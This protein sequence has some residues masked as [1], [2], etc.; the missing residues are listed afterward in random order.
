MDNR[1]GKRDFKADNNY[2]NTPLMYFIKLMF[3]VFVVLVFSYFIFSQIFLPA[4]SPSSGDY[5]YAEYKGEW[6]QV[7][8]DGSV[9]ES[10]TFPGK[11]AAQRGEKII[12]ET[13]LPAE[14][15]S[16]KY[17]CFRSSKQDMRIWIDGE[18][19]ADYNTNDTRVFGTTSA[20]A[21]VFVELFSS[22][23]GKTLTME[24]VTDSSYTGIFYSAYY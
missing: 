12:L 2:K 15:V 6:T 14:I 24:T 18:L 9:G 5:E 22:D 11:V 17:L 21:Y 23:A 3:G 8:E 16:N 4:D 1:F 10:I 19:R 13:T 20:V 7:K